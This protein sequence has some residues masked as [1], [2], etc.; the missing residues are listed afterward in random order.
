MKIKA[1]LPRLVRELEKVS[2]EFNRRDHLLGFHR[3]ILIYRKVLQEFL[4][5]I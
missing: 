2:L 3:S 5:L 1:P 4:V